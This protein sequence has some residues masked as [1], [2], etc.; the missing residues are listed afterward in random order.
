MELKVRN[1]LEKTD[2]SPIAH[3]ANLQ[4]EI[5]QNIGSPVSLVTKKIELEQKPNLSPS[6]KSIKMSIKTK[7]VP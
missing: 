7:S 6:R 2:L 5:V 4:I 3:S 1:L